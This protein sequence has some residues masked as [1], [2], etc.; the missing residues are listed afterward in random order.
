MISVFTRK[1]KKKQYIYA[2]EDDIFQHDKF[3][4]YTKDKN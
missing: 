1:K 3:S 2:R 4:S